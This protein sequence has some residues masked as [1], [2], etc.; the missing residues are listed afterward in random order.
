MKTN[1]I[2][3][4]P[5]LI[6]LH[7]Q[8]CM[9]SAL[10]CFIEILSSSLNTMLIVDKHCSDVCCDKSPVP[11]IDRKK[12]LRKNSNMEY[13][14]RNQYAE[15]LAISN[16][17]NI[18]ICASITKS[19]ATKMQLVGIFLHT[20]TLTCTRQSRYINRRFTYLLTC[21]TVVN[22]H[23]QISTNPQTQTALW[24]AYIKSSARNRPKVC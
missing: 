10:M 22:I 8:L 16:I 11:Q 21:S 9:L 20:L 19:K 2:F 13:F 12:E 14:I 15:K 18:K 17:E 6:P 7:V 24:P 3:S 4:A 1:C 23:R 5:I